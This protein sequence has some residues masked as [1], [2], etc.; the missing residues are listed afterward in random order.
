MY[1]HLWW[2]CCCVAFI[3]QALFMVI[4]AYVMTPVAA[5]TC[6]VLAVGVGGLAWAGFMVNMLDI[7]PSGKTDCVVF[8][9]FDEH[10]TSFFTRRMLEYLF[11]TKNNRK[12]ILSITDLYYYFKS[13]CLVVW[14]FVSCLHASMIIHGV[15]M[16][17]RTLCFVEYLPK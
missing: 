5:V 2:W 6:L 11:I 14:L 3:G 12:V 10:F 4:T 8:C 15:S 17:P 9:G 13:E 7:A 16:K 1:E